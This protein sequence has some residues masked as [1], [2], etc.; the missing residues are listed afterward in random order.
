MVIIKDEPKKLV[1]V[2]TETV[3]KWSAVALETEGEDINAALDAHAHQLIGEFETVSEAFA[4]CETYAAEWR[5]GKRADE[6]ECEEIN[7]PVSMPE[8]DAEFSDDPE[9]P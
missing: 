7:V 9:N 5:K 1:F 4:A 8:I 3:G 2:A 6:C